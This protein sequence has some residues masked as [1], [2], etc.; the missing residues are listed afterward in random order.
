MG[1]R[2]AIGVLAASVVLCA[3]AP[4]AHAAPPTCLSGTVSNVEAGQ[5]ISFGPPP[6]TDPEGQPLTYTILSGPAHGTLT[7]PSAQQTW[8][9]TASLG[10]EGTDAITYKATDAE[11]LDSNTAT[12]TI[13]VLDPAPR[14][15]APVLPVQS[16]TVLR[17][18]PQ[19]ADPEGEPITITVTQ[20]PAHGTFDPASW[21]YTPAR[22]YSGPDTFSYQASDG[23]RSSNIAT[24]RITVTPASGGG[25]T[26]PPPVVGVSVDIV[27]VSG[28]VLVK[29]PGQRTFRRLRVGEQLPVGTAVDVTNGRIRLTSAADAAGHT[30]TADFY[31]GRFTV[32]QAKA[33]APVTELQLD[34]PQCGA[35]AA[36][37]TGKKKK[38]N[39]VWGDGTGRF[40]TRG[41]YGSAA[42]RGTKWLTRDRCDG[43]FF[44]AAKGIVT[45]RDFVTRRTVVL[46]APRTYFARKR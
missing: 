44:R 5:S 24:A 1:I 11:A 33:A 18:Q 20:A 40:R 45:V 9:Y 28:T 43:T 19:C 10:Y 41:R 6:C 15:G 46:R 21:T 26:L 7:G 35:R 39:E 42:V 17:M 38:I 13:T 29:E 32:T 3:L 22:G 37:G 27:P 34:R 25:G 23:R 14:C 31:G 8:M 2:C 36:A 30:Q 12:H 16:G 4:A